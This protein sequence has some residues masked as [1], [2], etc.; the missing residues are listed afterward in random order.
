MG[1]KESKKEREEDWRVM[2]QGEEGRNA[3]D[4]QDFS[5]EQV[6]EN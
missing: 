1:G 3:V 4:L 6:V 2:E 5:I